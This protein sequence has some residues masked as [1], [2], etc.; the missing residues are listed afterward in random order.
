MLVR[1][2]VLG[3]G[4]LVRVSV[5]GNANAFIRVR[6]QNLVVTS[7]H[8]VIHRLTYHSPFSTEIYVDR[9]PHYL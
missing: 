4:V 3:N 7:A 2:S 1:V 5:L 9:L 8:T 6:I